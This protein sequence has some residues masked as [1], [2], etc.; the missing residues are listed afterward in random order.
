M[1][2]NPEFNPY[3]DQMKQTQV[4]KD[5][6]EDQ[7]NE[8]FNTK[9]KKS[10][11]I[12]TISCLVYNFVGIDI[13]RANIGLISGSTVQ[14]PQVISFF[15]FVAL[16]YATSLYLLALWKK[17]EYFSM[18]NTTNATRNKFISELQNLIISER[19]PD[20]LRRNSIWIKD[21]SIL[22]FRGND[23]QREF[24]IEGVPSTYSPLD[25]LNIIDDSR[26]ELI[27]PKS[28]QNLVDGNYH[29]LF[30]LEPSEKHYKFLDRYARLL[31]INNAKNFIEYRLPYILAIFALFSFLYR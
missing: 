10:M 23:R 6:E 21:V 20:F 11:Q 8:D 27:E 16:L 15:L 18:I 2:T 30:K 3:E 28:D 26:F 22:G 24:I 14:N 4:I 19:L 17:I 31:K 7:A 25:I 9:H 1:K 12:L 13:S 29:Y 5:L